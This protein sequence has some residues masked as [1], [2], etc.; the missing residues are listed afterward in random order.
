MVTFPSLSEETVRQ[1]A[2]AASWQRGVDYFET[3][4]VSDVVWREGTLTAQVEGSQIEPYHVRVRFDEQGNVREAFCS[5]PYEG[6]GDCKHV[7]ATLLVLIRRPEKVTARPAIRTLLEGQSRE[8]LL[9]LVL[10]LVEQ[11]PDTLQA[12]ED[13]LA[14]PA[15]SSEEHP[16]D[17]NLGAVQAQIKAAVREIGRSAYAAYDEAEEECPLLSEA[18]DP[19]VEQAE[20][21]LAQR[22]PRTALLVLEAATTAWIEGCRRLD[23]NFLGDIAELEEENLLPFAE[24]WSEALLSA[25]L[26]AG[27]RRAWE[28]KLESWMGTMIGGGA[29][30]MPLTA[31]RQ[32]WDYPP[33]VAAMQGDFDQRGAWEGEAPAF[34]DDLAQV[35]LRILKARGRYQEA[36]HLAEAEGQIPTY[37]QL[38]VEAG[39]S[40]QAASEARRMLQDPEAVLSLAKTLL[41]RGETDL[42]LDLAAH[43]LT[44]GEARRRGSLAEWLREQAEGHGRRDLALQAAWEALRAHP[45]VENYRWLQSHLGSEW[46]TYQPQALDI[47]AG[48]SSYSA[49]GEIIEIYLQEKMYP[50]AMALVEKNPW[51]GKLDKVIQTVSTAFPDWAFSQCYRQAADIMDNGRA[52]DYDT[53]IAWLREGRAILL[54]AG[55]AERWQAALG[56]LLQKHQRKYKLRPMLE[57]LGGQ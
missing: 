2:T 16:T 30:E 53:A 22:E 15:I 6:G 18:L 7:I 17:V 40:E 42:G 19:V 11:S 3:G 25:D 35:R 5:C 33:L 56:E 24:V 43:G 12:I 1:R 57:K 10:S 52:A 37:L 26:S 34:A 23:Q 29:L 51:S 50:Q 27:E 28:R 46:E 44:L 45:T 36:I 48:H 49:M 20:S 54:A 47:V 4:A 31:A 21:L 55:Q 41:E 8:Q 9:A 32:G 14:A 38:L 39:N 13:F